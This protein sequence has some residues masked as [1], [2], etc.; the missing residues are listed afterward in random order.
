MEY[1]ENTVI[2]APTSVG[3]THT[4]ATTPWL[5]Y[6]ELTG[7]NLVIHV[8]QTTKARDQAVQESE[9]AERVSYCV[10]KGREDACPIAAG[11]YDDSFTAPHGL[12]PSEWFEWMCDVRKIGFQK[13]HRKL[14]HKYNL[15]C[16]GNCPALK[17]WW[18]DFRDEDGNPTVDLIHTTANFAHV[19]DLIDGANLVFDER[20]AYTLTLGHEERQQ[21]RDS[22]SNLLD[23]RSNGKYAVSDITTANRHG[24]PQK[25]RQLRKFSTSQ[26]RLVRTPAC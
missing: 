11:E 4:T 10:F 12:K 1:A 22:I 15:P 17:Q 2:G 3:K 24:D 7:G 9:E 21:I 13:A 20:P 18:Q 23:Y 26:S 5:E 16:G 8:H 6:P 14:E 25:T 19:E